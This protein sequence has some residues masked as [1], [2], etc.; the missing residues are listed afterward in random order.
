MNIVFFGVMKE[1]LGGLFI[2]TLFG[3]FLQKAGVTK[4]RTIKNQLLLKD[5]TVMKVILTAIGT[6]GLFLFL[7]RTFVEN[8]ALIISTTTL[9]AALAG[10]CIFGIG[11]ATLGF[12][13]G[14]CIGA[15]AEKSKTA[16][17]GLIGM[18]VG[19]FL[20]SKIAGFIHQNFKQKDA[21]NQ[22]TLPDVFNISPLFFILFILSTVFILWL[23]EKNILFIKARK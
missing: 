10:G 1:V 7:Y 8:K 15:I 20:Y 5:F 22:S 4:F 6:G 3:F 11:M 21:I 9:P 12:C 2:G 18:I 17:F 19:A 13:P 23:I 14:T 16:F